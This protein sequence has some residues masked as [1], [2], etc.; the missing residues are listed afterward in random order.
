MSASWRQDVD[1]GELPPHRP[2]ARAG[3]AVNFR[4]DTLV[5]G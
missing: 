5:T 2:T 1:T 3:A 4:R